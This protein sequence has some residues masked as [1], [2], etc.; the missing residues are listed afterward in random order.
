MSQKNILNYASFIVSFVKPKEGL[1]WYFRLLHSFPFIFY[2]QIEISVNL[3]AAQFLLQKNPCF[4]YK[5]VNPILQI[6]TYRYPLGTYITR[7]SEHLHPDRHKDNFDE[8]LRLL[9]NWLVTN[10]DLS[11]IVDFLVP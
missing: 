4:L 2:I 11:Q 1:N 5:L 9:V 6:K 7:Q 10:V 8:S 3:K